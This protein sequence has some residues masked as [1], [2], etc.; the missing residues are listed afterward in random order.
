[1]RLSCNRYLHGLSLH[2]QLKQKNM[3]R[4]CKFVPYSDVNNIDGTIGVSPAASPLFPLPIS[5]VGDPWFGPMQNTCMAGFGSYFWFPNIN[6]TDLQFW[7][8]NMYQKPG[9]L[10][11]SLYLYRLPVLNILQQQCTPSNFVNST[12]FG[13][14]E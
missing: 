5:A 13:S 3:V 8:N 1:M 14:G 4:D 10:S 12:I 2:P 7:P 6:S 11:S 9:G